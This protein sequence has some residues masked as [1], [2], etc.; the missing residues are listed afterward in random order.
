MKH[1]RVV[2]VSMIEKNERERNVNNPEEIMSGDCERGRR[3]GGEGWGRGGRRRWEKE[4]TMRRRAIIVVF[5]VTHDANCFSV[6]LV[7]VVVIL[8]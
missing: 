6:G 5:Y 3:V 4:V 8:Q 7:V 2:F 1:L